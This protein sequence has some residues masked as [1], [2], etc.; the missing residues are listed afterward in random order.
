MGGLLADPKDRSY[1]SNMTQPY[2]ILE[3]PGATD[4]QLQR[5]LD[6]AATVLTAAGLTPYEAARGS[7]ER[8]GLDMKG[9]SAEDAPSD[10]ILAA[11]VVWD[12]ACTAA[13]HACCEGWAE[14]PEH[15]P[16][17]GIRWPKKDA[18]AA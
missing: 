7:F 2:L 10:R 3:V 5:G 8:E 16:G 11:A 9:W 1:S 14:A 18:E 6:A 15:P 12:E 4:E 13:D 17:L